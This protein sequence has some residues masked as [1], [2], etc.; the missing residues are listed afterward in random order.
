M[1]IHMNQIMFLV[2]CSIIGWALPDY[3]NKEALVVICCAGIGACML[4]I[5]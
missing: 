3:K 5:N 1:S 4:L 2:A